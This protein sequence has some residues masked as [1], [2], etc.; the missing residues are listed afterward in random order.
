MPFKIYQPD[1]GPIDP[2]HYLDSRFLYKNLEKFFSPGPVSA[3]FKTKSSQLL[4]VSVDS[5]DAKTGFKLKIEE[6][7]ASGVHSFFT[8]PG[9]C[10]SGLEVGEF[11]F[12]LQR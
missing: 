3:I 1:A 4:P 10:V 11:Q 8:G 6:P 5:L 12:S 7:P 9:M 2:K